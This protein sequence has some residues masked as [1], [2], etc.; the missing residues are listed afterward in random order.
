MK[1]VRGKNG[2][3]KKIRRKRKEERNGNIFMI[4]IKIY[5]KRF[6]RAL[7]FSEL[8]LIFIFD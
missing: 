8:Y 3:K 1:E 6:I 4:C 7:L 2:G 5:V